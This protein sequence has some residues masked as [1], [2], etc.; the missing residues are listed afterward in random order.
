MRE[1]RTVLMII[2][3]FALQWSWSFVLAKTFEFALVTDLHIGQNET[4]VDDLKNSILT[5]NNT[6][7]V[8]F[9][10]VSGDLTEGGD[11]ESLLKTKQML[12]ELKVPYFAVPGNHETKWSESGVMDFREIFGNDRFRFDYE[13]FVFLGFNSGPVIRMMDGHVGIQ[14][15]LWLET[16]LKSIESH[17]NIIIIMHY[18]LQ[19]GDVDN[20]YEL[21]DL[22][23]RYNVKAILGGH[24]H[25]NRLT[26]Y[27]G[28]PAFINRSNLRGK[29]VAGGFSVY[30]VNE[31]SILVSEQI[32]GKFARRWGGYSLQQKYYTEDASG[33]F[34]PD[35]SVNEQFLKVRELWMIK[36]NGAVYSSP[37]VSGNKV[38]VGDDLGV[39]SCYTLNEGKLLWQYAAKSCILGTPA[40]SKKV[41]VF[42]STDR[43]IYG[44][45][46]ETGKLIWKLKTDASVIGA[47]TIENDRAYVGGSDHVFR[48]IDIKKGKV[49]WQYNEVTGYVETKPLLYDD[50]V[51]FG[52]W[53]SYM[54]ALNKRSGRLLWKWNNGNERMHFSPAA[55]WPVAAHGKIFFTAP[56]RVMTALNADNGSVLWRTKES[57]VRETIGLSVDKK[58]I[59]SKTMQDSVVCYSTTTD[60]PRRIWSVN[61]AYGY[62][63]APSMPVEKQNI[64]YGSTKNGLIFALDALTGKVLWKH[65]VGNSLINTVS[66][67]GDGRCVFTSAEG[68][69][70]VLRS[71]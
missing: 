30:S 40:A 55:V 33:Y 69:V 13:N 51:V 17:K 34:R 56:D 61:V 18:P 35:Y 19:N 31:D 22:L 38:Y 62:D 57:M 42:G 20:W 29:E 39:L 44:V 64:V 12:D 21:T 48:C 58:R 60:T 52:A 11:R 28:I 63:H 32:I 27:D 5:I 50:K 16:E 68:Y 37:V 7:E 8:N 23:R 67:L 45:N 59:Y 10:F 24:Y 66:P 54:Y 4:S 14:D 25:T 2:I 41:L 47:V 65:K 26:D 49:I 70:G 1:L 36:N 71:E 15:I 3:F 43:Y 6:P 9:V 46:A 53:D